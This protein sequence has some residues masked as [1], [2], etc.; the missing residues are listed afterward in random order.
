MI[1]QVQGLLIVFYI[2][3]PLLSSNISISYTLVKFHREQNRTETLK[4]YFNLLQQELLKKLHSSQ[5]SI[6]YVLNS[7]F[8]FLS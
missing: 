2:V 3:Y 4:Y 7:I 6:S 1:N 8:N 5:K